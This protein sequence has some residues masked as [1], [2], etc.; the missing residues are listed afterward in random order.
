MTAIAVT[1]AGSDSSGGA[2]IQADLKTFAALGVYG[3][4]VITALTAQNTKGVTGIHDVPPEF[5]TAQIDAVFSDLNVG[6]VKIGMLSNAPSSRRL[7][8]RS[9]AIIRPISCSTGDGRDLRRP[10]AHAR[11]GRTASPPAHSQISRGDANL[12][13]AAALLDTAI[14]EDEAVMRHQA[15][16]ILKLGAKAVLIKGGPRRRAREHRPAG[17]AEQDHSCRPNASPRA[18]P[19]A[20]LH[21]VGG[22]RGGARQRPGPHRGGARGKSYVTAAIAAAERLSI[23]SGHGPVHHFHRQW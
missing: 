1:I 3:A 2:G 19:T 18:T 7:L 13:E 23:G 22:D 5:V 11:R 6:A 14:A 20:R 9:S 16:R 4:S 10:A 17:R 8:R 12:P 15:H 21:A